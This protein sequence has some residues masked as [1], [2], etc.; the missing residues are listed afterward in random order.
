MKK[1]LFLGI[2]FSLLW[3]LLSCSDEPTSVGVNLIDDDVINVSSFDTK[4]T[5]VYQTSTYYKKVVPLGLSSKILIGKRNDI[6]ASTLMKFLFFIDD[7]LKDD[8]L[9]DAININEA[10][11]ELTPQY[12]F[13][14]EAADMDF[15]VHKINSDWSAN[16]FTIDSLPALVYETD[17]LSSNKN[18]TDSLYTFD[19]SPDLVLSWIKNSYDSTLESNKGIYYKPTQ[20]SGKVV[21]FQALTTTST[22]A[23]KIKIVIEKPGAFIDTVK[24]FIFLDV[25][26]V[27]SDSLILPQGEIGVQASVTYQ[28]KLFFDISSLSNDIVINN[29][30]LILT[31][32]TLNF[33]TGTSYSSYVQVFKITDSTKAEIDKNSGITLIRQNDIYS[34]NITNIFS[35]W[36][37]NNDV[38]GLIIRSENV[39]EGLELFTFRGS[40]YPDSALR[41]RIRVT[42]TERRK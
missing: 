42:F 9:N 1:F 20:S 4:D 26:V 23:A 12:T 18:F 35:S 33:I 2:L 14:D 7:S 11:I 27:D 13:T 39:S 36:L 25:S 24:G 32:D 5:P 34:G 19:L 17:D 31:A 6:V 21:G 37:T 38:Q 16:T 15:T 28:S 10:F 29:A 40:D 3:L 8:F 30:E 22:D 41:P